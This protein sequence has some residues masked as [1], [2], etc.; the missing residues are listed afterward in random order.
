MKNNTWLKVFPNFL[1]CN[2]S[3]C[4]QRR[5]FCKLGPNVEKAEGEIAG[6][7]LYN[8]ILTFYL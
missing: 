6:E 1:L 2:L 5:I 7:F 4:V 3:R 8:S